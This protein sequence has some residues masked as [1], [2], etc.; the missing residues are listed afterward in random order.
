MPLLCVLDSRALKLVWRRQ[1]SKAIKMS[2]YIFLPYLVQPKC[3][4]FSK[5]LI[6]LN[7]V[8]HA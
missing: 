3:K 8:A 2:I 1:S 4:N 6:T 7:L 5:F